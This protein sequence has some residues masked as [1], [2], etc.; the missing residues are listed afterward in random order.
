MVS[1]VVQNG[2]DLL[3]ALVEPVLKVNEGFVTPDLLLNFFASH[4][5]SG[6]ADEQGKDSERLRRQLEWYSAFVQ[7]FAIEIELEDAE[8]EKF[9][10]GAQYD[11]LTGRSLLRPII[12]RATVPKPF[13]SY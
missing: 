6:V 11:H 9:L 12:C 7:F 3:D 10:R 2:P 13:F 4:D 1:I 8:A 5:L